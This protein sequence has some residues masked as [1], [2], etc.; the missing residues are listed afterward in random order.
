M[1]LGWPAELASAGLASTNL[2]CAFAL[3]ECATAAGTGVCDWEGR[4]LLNIDFENKFEN[5]GVAIGCSPVG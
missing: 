3:G 1:A 2:D 5:V 4:Y